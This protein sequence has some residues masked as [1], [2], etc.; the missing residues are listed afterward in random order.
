[1][2]WKKSEQIIPYLLFLEQDPIH[3]DEQLEILRQ[4]LVLLQP[5]HRL[6]LKYLMAHLYR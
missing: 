1:M 2:I 5:A 6:T 3:Q 4:T